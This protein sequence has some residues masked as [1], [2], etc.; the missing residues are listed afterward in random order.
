MFRMLTWR[1]TIRM[2]AHSPWLGTGPG[3]YALAYR[4][5][6]IGGYT[7]LAHQNYLQVAAEN[8][9]IGG[10]GFLALV[11]AALASAASAA[12]RLTDR[13]ERTVAAGV[14]AGLV[15]FAI[16][17]LFDSTWYVS[18]IMLAFWWLAGLATMARRSVEPPCDCLRPVPAARPVRLALL[19]LAAV[20][21]AALIA[22]V[23]RTARA[24]RYLARSSTA[25]RTGR[26][27]DALAL[28]RAAA[29]AD[30]GSARAHR[31]TARI[32]GARK[33]T[34]PQ[35][36]PPALLASRLEPTD[37]KHRRLLA[38]IYHRLGDDESHEQELINAIRLAPSDPAVVLKLADLHRRQARHLE[39]RDG[40]RRVVEIQRSPY[41]LHRAIPESVETAYAFAHYRLGEYA[42]NGADNVEAA[43]PWTA[44]PEFKAALSVLQRHD[45]SV[46]MR[47]ERV[48]RYDVPSDELPGVLSALVTPE[49]PRWREIFA[50]LDRID[51]QVTQE[52]RTLVGYTPSKA[53]AL[54]DLRRSLYQ[55]LV[56]A[57]EQRAEPQP[58]AAYRQRL[59]ALEG[60]EP[61]LRPQGARHAE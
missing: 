36:L 37:P 9:L 1:G 59:R 56:I 61:D 10:L 60:S 16:H 4:Q 8:G 32:L 43:G 18:A 26:V 27:E 25:E 20:V 34:L 24:Q 2:I 35:A 23:A 57:Y 53:R 31:Q 52:F 58:A 46:R 45:K 22:P 49:G 38:E 17:G 48:L 39:A 54:Y 51:P 30:P 33:T 28:A 15:A 14:L 40:Y 3:T 50:R 55:S 5:H 47:L 29:A 42:L 6:A 21:S 7:T 44:A 41:E 12:R 11:A 19:L 13:A